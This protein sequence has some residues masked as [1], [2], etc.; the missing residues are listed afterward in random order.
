MY[1]YLIDFS[2]QN[3]DL[4]NNDDFS[5]MEAQPDEGI[6]DYD[7]D[8]PLL[9]LDDVAKLARQSKVNVH[10]EIAEVSNSK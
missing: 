9:T 2:Y 5:E 6:P 1:I 8:V 10:N 3:V 4:T 7:D